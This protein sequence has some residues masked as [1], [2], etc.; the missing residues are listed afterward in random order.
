MYW[1]QVY[2]P[3]L[4]SSPQL[5]WGWHMCMHPQAW[6]RRPDGV[7]L[8]SHG[9]WS[10][11]SGQKD[12]QNAPGICLFISPGWNQRCAPAHTALSH[13]CRGTLPTSSLPRPICQLLLGYIE[14]FSLTIKDTWPQ[15]D[16]PILFSRDLRVWEESLWEGSKEIRG[17]TSW[18]ECEAQVGRGTRIFQNHLIIQSDTQLSTYI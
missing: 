17:H 4:W 1:P 8:S 6:Q 15:A 3:R 14:F 7:S 13:G 2:A 16:H 18:A 9:T 11:P 10:S 5:L 12:G